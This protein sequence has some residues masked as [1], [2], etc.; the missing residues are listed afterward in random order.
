VPLTLRE[1]RWIDARLGA[2]FVWARRGRPFGHGLARR[3]DHYWRGL[4]RTSL[5]DAAWLQQ[6]TS[7]IDP[8]I[9]LHLWTPTTPMAIKVGIAH[10]ALRRMTH[11]GPAHWSPTYVANI[12]A[13]YIAGDVA[14]PAATLQKLWDASAYPDLLLGTALASARPRPEIHALLGTH[15]WPA[16]WG[17]LAACDWARP[18]LRGDPLPPHS[19]KLLPDA[20]GRRRSVHT[21]LDASWTATADNWAGWTPVLIHLTTLRAPLPDIGARVA[22]WPAGPRTLVA[23]VLQTSPDPALAALGHH[24]AAL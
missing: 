6:P 19:E 21:A 18:L 5:T 4:I 23:A 16:F 15:T 9:L 12:V 20:A 8:A 13:V 17:A 1:Q 10:H 2:H 3:L 22:R 7:E 11:T 24:L 14:V